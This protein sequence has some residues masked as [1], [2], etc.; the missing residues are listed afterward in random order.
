MVA[1]RLSEHQRRAIVA[2]QFEMQL[3]KFPLQLVERIT[4]Y[5]YRIF[6]KIRKE[7]M[8]VTVLASSF[9]FYEYRMN[10]HKY[11]VS[12]IICQHHNASLP[13]WVLELDTAMMYKPVA[14]PV[15]PVREVPAGKKMRRTQDEMKVLLS[16]LITGVDS[17]YDELK[18]MPLRS[19]QRYLELRTRYLKTKVGR[20]WL[21]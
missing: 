9:D 20:P 6:D 18:K 15:L 7:E 14:V 4:N 2:R 11:G 21:S 17:A 10:L 16:Q 19:K 12:L 8:L 13:M 5:R 1:G 3:P